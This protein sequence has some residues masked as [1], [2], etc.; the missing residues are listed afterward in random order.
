M[1]LITWNQKRY[2]IGV[3]SI[4]QQHQQLVNYINILAEAINAQQS[5]EII[6]PLFQQL[7]DYT[8]HHFKEEEQYFYRL[9][10]NDRLLHKLQHK[11]FIE[12]LTRIKQLSRQLISNDLLFFLT[13]WFINHILGE[14]QK[15]IQCSCPVMSHPPIK[16]RA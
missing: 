4:D 6:E 11:H 15:F 3:E 8:L 16:Q 13:D 7:Y 1:P 14:D 2:G 5:N 10:K 12:E 9:S